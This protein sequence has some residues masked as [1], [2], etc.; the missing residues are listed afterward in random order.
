V[1]VVADR[2]VVVEQDLLTRLLADQSG[3]L[4]L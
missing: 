3:Q 4:H 1:T 2:G